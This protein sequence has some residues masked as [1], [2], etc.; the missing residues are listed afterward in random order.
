MFIQGLVD[1]IPKL[2][3]VRHSFGYDD[4]YSG[5]YASKFDF[6]QRI[7]CRHRS[8]CLTPCNKKDGEVPYYR[9]YSE[10]SETRLYFKGFSLQQLRKYAS[11]FFDQSECRRCSFTTL[12]PVVKCQWP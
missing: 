2:V 12:R 3:M 6:Y 5:M 7:G 4:V 11:T 10:V 9:D 1:K 8:A